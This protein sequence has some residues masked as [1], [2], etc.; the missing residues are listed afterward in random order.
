MQM[1]KGQR[2]ALKGL[3][4]F[5]VLLLIAGAGSTGYLIGLKKGTGGIP[6]GISQEDFAKMS[7]FW[8]AWSILDT[9]FYGELDTTKRIDGAISGMTAGLGDPFTNYLPPKANKQFKSSIQGSFVGIGAELELKN[10]L[11]T[12]IAPLADSPAE[13]A[14]L[15]TGDVIL[16][17]DGQDAASMNFTDAI[18]SIRGEKG[19]IV[20]LTI[21]RTGVDKNF[22]MKITRD[23]IVIKS[24]TQQDIADGQISYI[25]MNMFG[26]DTTDLYKGFLQKAVSENKKGIVLDLRNNPG[27]LLNSAVEEIGMVLPATIESDN[28]FLKDRIGVREKYKDRPESKLPSLSEPIADKIPLVI[29]VNGGSA[30]ASEIFAGAMKDYNRAKLVGEKTFGKGSVQNVE[31]LSNG[32][33][34]KVTVAHWLTPLGSEIH[35]KGI[36][37]DFTVALPEGA[38]PTADD[39]QVKKALELLGITSK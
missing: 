31:D 17:I 30:S 28:E 38:K 8:D 25:K 4:F 16:K 1:E 33:S 2:F 20:T 18:D 29:L 6:K 14:D 36:E 21:A 5:I 22:E 35:G 34:I 37:P 10:G 24:V 32:G 39:A 9:N 3:L 15:R 26:L 12:V 27:G 13:K 7:N 11:I 19:T 23:T